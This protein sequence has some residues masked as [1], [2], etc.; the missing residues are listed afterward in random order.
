VKLRSWVLEGSDDGTTWQEIDAPENWSPPSHRL[1]G[2][3]T[4]SLCVSASEHRSGGRTAF[5]YPR[6]RP[7]TSRESGDS[8]FAL[9]A[10]EFFG[11]LLNYPEEGMQG[12]LEGF[13]EASAEEGLD[14]E[15]SS[16]AAIL[17]GFSDFTIFDFSSS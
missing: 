5:R 15:D 17:T 16:H 1:A 4:A 6:L 3:L 7:P 9:H 10:V 14:L 13:D 11:T 12:I 2:P 8:R